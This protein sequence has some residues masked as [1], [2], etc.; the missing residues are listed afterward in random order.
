MWQ[1]IRRRSILIEGERRSSID[2]A[3]SRLTILGAFFIIGYVVIVARLMDL[4]VVQGAMSVTADRSGFEVAQIAQRRGDIYDRNGFLVATTLKTPS[5]FVD[6][7]LVMDADNLAHDLMSV[8]DGLDEKVLLKSLKARNRFAWIKRNITP[9]QHTQILNIGS[10]ALG[11]QYEYKRVY[12]QGELFAHMLGYTDR[13]GLGL[14]G[15]ERGF[16]DVLA[17]GVDVNLSFDLR[18]QH[19]ARR[20]L[21]TA[22]SDFE[23]KAGTAVIMDVKSGE[24][25]AS[26]SLPDFDLNKASSAGANEKFNRLTLGVYELGSM[27]K[28]FSTAALFDLV[29]A[30]MSD[31]FDARKP[32]K[33]GRFTINDYHAQKRILTVPE[34]FMHSSNIGSAMMGEKVGGDALRA[35]YKDLGLLDPLMFDIKEVGRPLLPKPWRHV[36]T[37][38]AAYGHGL[39]T[40]PLQMSAA[41]ASVVNGG[42]FV[43]P[44]IEKRSGDEGYFRSDVR[45]ISE[46]TSENIRKLLRLTV[47]E[48]TGKN[49]DVKGY[50][51]GG[52]TGTAEKSVNGRYDRSL[53]ISSF[54][55]A[56]PI[57]DPRYVVMVMVDEPK[58]QKHSYGYATAGWVA[59]PAVS[60]IVTSMAS[61]LGM[62]ADQH[63]L[64]QDISD[65]LLPYIYDPKT[66]AYKA[67]KMVKGAQRVSY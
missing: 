24:L 51:V 53:L 59:A 34:V 32:I 63:N 13:D 12:P 22:I 16:D 39:A 23:A 28:I 25:L 62:P 29:G 9:E 35:F 67:P 1:Q 44:T 20:E 5:L 61:V 66:K 37:L 27:F 45:V 21:S 19:I 55:G 26:V 42:L 47:T 8:I 3:Q 48:G 33:V 57:D 6:P 10:P 2:M 38:T 41:V 56:F 43:Q 14:S 18:L 50:R 52:K 64:D 49:A 40:T 46:T 60:R 54:V 31:T 11:V 15:A 65:E 58:G 30:R 36:N 4:S 7:S 17:Q